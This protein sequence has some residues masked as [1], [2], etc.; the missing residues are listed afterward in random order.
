[1]WETDGNTACRNPFSR[2]M[3]VTKVV[4]MSSRK[5]RITEVVNLIRESKNDPDADRIITATTGY[6]KAFISALRSDMENGRY[7]EEQQQ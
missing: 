4:A 6:S 1:M 2:I 3:I 7:H 5:H